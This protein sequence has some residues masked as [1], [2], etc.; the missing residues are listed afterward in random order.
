[1]HFVETYWAVAGAA[2]PVLGLAAIVAFGRNAD[3]FARLRNVPEQTRRNLLSPDHKESR[4]QDDKASDRLELPDGTG[5]VSLGLSIVGTALALVSLTWGRN[6]SP[7]ILETSILLLAFLGLGVQ[8][9]LTNAGQS[10]LVE[11]F[12]NESPPAS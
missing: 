4:R 5:F 3:S 10:H 6:V 1:M 2:Q 8:A 7:P 9:S 11:F 12:R